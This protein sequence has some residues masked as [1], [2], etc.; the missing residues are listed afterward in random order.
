MSRFAVLLQNESRRVVKDKT[1][2][3]GTFDLELEF[4]PQAVLAGLPVGASPAS[5]DRPSL[6]TALQEQLGLKLESERGPVDVL[7][8]DSAEPPAPD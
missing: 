1:A 4:A 6:F 5:S 3:T 8:I 2:L 7:T